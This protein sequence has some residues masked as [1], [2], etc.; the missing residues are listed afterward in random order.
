MYDILHEKLSI[1]KTDRSK[2]LNE[3]FVMNIFDNLAQELPPFADHLEYIFEM[4][5][6]TTIDDKIKVLP[7]GL[8]QCELFYPIHVEN[9]ESTKLVKKLADDV[10]LVWINELE[11]P[12]KAT[13]YHL[14]SSEGKWSWGQTPDVKKK[15]GLG[16][17][18]T[19]DIAESPFAVM[20]EEYHK[21]GAS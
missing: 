9:Q 11:D 14:S 10:S 12:K 6:N 16:K 13:S 2:L 17:Q 18:A 19:N 21:F 1:I 8:I 3:D 20:K 15:A 7:A 4:K 5:E